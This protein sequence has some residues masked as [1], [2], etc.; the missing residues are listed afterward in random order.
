MKTPID[1]PVRFSDCETDEQR[2]EFAQYIVNTP[3]SDRP[4][5]S[6]EEAAAALSWMRGRGE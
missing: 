5:V 6:D 3:A 4:E 1:S 2:F